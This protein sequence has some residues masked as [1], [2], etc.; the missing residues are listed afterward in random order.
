MKTR[1]FLVLISFSF[2][3]NAFAQ[4]EQ[5][6][7]I[8]RGKVFD[9]VTQ[10]PL[11]GA[12][13][14]IKNNVAL[15]ALTNSYGVFE[16]VGVPIGRQTIEIT[17]IGYKTRLIENV[18][19]IS[20]KQM[21]ID[22]ALEEEA[23]QI[24]QVVVRANANKSSLNEMAS[25][26][27]RAIS[28]EQTERF[29]GSLGDP[30]RMVAN[31][32]GVSSKDDSR[33]DIVIR[34]NS[35]G[36]VLWRL[37]GI[38]IPNP[39]HFGA[40][41]A[42]G[43][44]VSMI[45]NNLLTASDF[46]T[47]AF[48]AEYGNALAGA[49]DLYLRQGNTQKHEFTGQVGFNGFELGAEGPLTNKETQNA[50]YLINYRY[51]T[52]DV[53]H[54]L[55]INLGTGAAVPQY[56][57]LT[58]NIVIPTEKAGKF[59][60]FGLWG[61]SFI[62]LGREQADTTENSYNARGTATDFGSGLGAFGLGH[63]YY[64][65][66]QTRLRTTVSFQNTYVTTVYDSVKNATIV[67]PVFR[68]KQTQNK[69]SL[70]QQATYKFSSKTNM[71]IGYS[72]DLYQ[73]DFADS[74]FVAKYNS[75]IKGSDASGDFDLLQ[76]YI[77]AQHK[78]TNAITCNVGVHSQLFSLNNQFVVEPRLG[79]EYEFAKNHAVSFGYGLHNQTQPHE[80]YF[81][82]FYDSITKTYSKPNSNLTFTQNTHYILGYNTRMFDVWKCKFELYYQYIQH[83]PVSSEYPTYSMLNAGADFTVPRIQN[84]KNQG[85]GSNKG[86]ELT[87][88][89]VL[90]H[91]FYVLFTTSLF[92][93]KYKDYNGVER[94]TAFNGN[95][96][97]NTLTGYEIT[98]KKNKML[99]FDIRAV[100][101]GGK[102]YIP[103]DFEASKLANDMV[104]DWNSIYDK[105][106]D[107]YFRTDL[108]IGYK[109][110]GKR[111]T[112]EYGLDLQ[113]ITNYKSVFMEAYD[114][115]KKEVYYFY[116]QGFMPMML[117]R[118]NF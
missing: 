106:Y 24:S 13:V 72:Y 93:S 12:M 4:Q 63:T 47:G 28:V 50:S 77:Q 27:A 117:Y 11:T 6:T 49:F 62:Q 17:Y 29:A 53:M 59:T 5:S 91:G 1:L 98:L 94:N 41:G 64:F 22:I 3:V 75:F 57:D 103:I 20:G 56:K 115:E 32:A 69:I 88:E 73:I 61:N 86:V 18:L 10:Y 43:G 99:T 25:V 79:I 55:G 44:P 8:I 113:N 114:S 89:R 34:G 81:Q 52:L 95:Y 76:A 92:D 78:P 111:I 54:K 68:Q 112:Q 51:S 101:A 84:L 83:A 16:I 38:E 116:Q 102:R 35:P 118:I 67:E 14:T 23:V 97:V 107:P 105:K 42:T 96:I 19:I 31:Y 71:K 46:I 100:Y 65:N 85:T 80:V 58:Y 2:I 36:G 108:R 7:Q 37:N 33:N 60:V 109:E 30:A 39:N 15:T 70:N 26:S 45:N 66:P 21:V 82:Q 87:I 48:P 74:T 90:E 9:A 104:Y 110:N 40:L